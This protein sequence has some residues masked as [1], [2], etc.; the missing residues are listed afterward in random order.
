MELG[1]NIPSP[2]PAPPPQPPG[3]SLEIPL[4]G[5]GRSR[6]EWLHA[7]NTILSN[8]TKHSLL[9]SRPDGAEALD[10]MAVQ[11]NWHPAEGDT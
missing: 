3:N 8:N 11:A 2:S 5:N 4:G 9:P 1:K 6:D 10:R 7:F